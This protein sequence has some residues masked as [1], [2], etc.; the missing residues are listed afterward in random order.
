MFPKPKK[1][2]YTNLKSYRVITLLNCL[3]KVLEKILATRL[4]FLANIGSLLHHTQMGSRKQRSAIDTA[5]LLQHY[6]QQQKATR[7]NN[8]TSV[9]FLDIKGAFDHVSKPKLLAAMQN[10]KLPL[11]LINWVELFLSERSIRLSFDNNVQNEKPIEIE[12]P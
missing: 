6:I 7:K 3:G 9:L 4:S 10:L 12:V 8:I 1:E 11:S 5:L 2:D